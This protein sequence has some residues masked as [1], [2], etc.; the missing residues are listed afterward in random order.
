V[1]E[2]NVTPTYRRFDAFDRTLHVLLMASFFGLSISGLPLLFST[3]VWANLAARALGGL[4]LAGRIHRLSAALLIA[5]F[6]VH[7][8]RIAKRLIVG[9]DLGVLWGPNS[10][11]PQP[12][13]AAD[14][15]QH[16]KWFIGRGPRPRFGRYTY[17]EKFDYWAV[18]WGMAI[19][20]GSGIMLAFKEKTASIL[21]GWVF[22]VATLVHGEEAILAAVFLF[23]VHFFNNHFRPDKLPPPDIVM[24]TGTVPLDEFRREHSLEYQRLVASGELAAPLVEAPS[25]QMTTGSRVLGLTLIAFGLTLLVLVLYGLA[26]SLP[27]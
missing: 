4:Y 21:P 22:N 13:D 26:S 12:R 15:Y 7:L 20:G 1:A 16:V 18:F 2:H 9:R 23:T 17:W 3:S 19:I 24:F 6:L 27:A 8:A 11:V 14:L 25:R 10:M 5:V